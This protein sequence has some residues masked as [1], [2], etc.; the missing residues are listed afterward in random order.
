MYEY[1][2]KGRMICGVWKDGI[3]LKIGIGEAEKAIAE[4]KGAVF[5][6]AGRPMKGWIFME[7]KRI[8]PEN[9]ETWLGMAKSYASSADR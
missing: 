1:M 8:T 7:D 2:W 3:F 6:A 4:S 5:D 9:I